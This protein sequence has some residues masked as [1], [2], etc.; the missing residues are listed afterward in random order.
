[1]KFNRKY[2][3]I[4][5]PLTLLVI[6]VVAWSFQKD[7]F[8]LEVKEAHR[9]SLENGYALSLVQLEDLKADHEVMLVDVRKEEAY[10]KGH[11][12]GAVSVPLHLLLEQENLRI[13]RK[14]EKPVIIYSDDMAETT[15]A[16]ALL[17]QLGIERMYMI[18]IPSG[19]LPSDKL[20][21]AER[22]YK[23]E[24]LRYIFKPDSTA[25]RMFE[26]REE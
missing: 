12:E 14:S 17:C 6:L 18:E 26:S 25:F 9:L 5:I 22:L 2:L 7:V 1:M 3:L 13:L 15:A 23:D 11:P 4:F 21:A 16:F 20:N 19:L 10:L 8:R 24:A